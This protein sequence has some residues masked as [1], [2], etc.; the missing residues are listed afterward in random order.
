MCNELSVDLLTPV[1][2]TR[3]EAERLLAVRRRPSLTLTG[4]TL[5]L[6]GPEDR[7]SLA[8]RRLILDNAQIVLSGGSLTI[9]VEELTVRGKSR[10]ASFEDPNHATQGQPGRRGGRVVVIVHRAIVGELV[11]DLRGQRGGD[12]SQG[13]PGLPGRPGA[14]GQNGVSGLFDCRSGPGRGLPGGPGGPGE[15]GG[16]GLP[17]GDGGTALLVLGPNVSER[18]V[19]VELDGGPGGSG[20]SGGPGG[21]GGPGVPGGGPNGWCQGH[22]PEGENGPAG[23]S[24]PQG[25][26]GDPGNNGTRPVVPLAAFIAEARR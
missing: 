8:V 15:A 10:I 25:P 1:T 2:G 13:Q 11:L 4:S 19:K 3:N 24:G 26:S 12:G 16:A 6:S 18:A 5:K 20:G 7:Q 9:E 23:P 14:R 17:G 22:G 21:P